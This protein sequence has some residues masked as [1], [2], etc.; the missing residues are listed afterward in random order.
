MTDPHAPIQVKSVSPV[1]VSIRVV[2][3]VT[4][5]PPNG[6][7]SPAIEHNG[8]VYVSGQLGRGPAMTDEAAGNIEVQTR[9][10]LAAVA[11]ILEAAG[12][13]MSLLL[14]VNIYISDVALWGDVN[15]VYRQVLGEHRP[16]RAIIPVA[17]LHF[18]ALL[19]IDAIAAVKSVATG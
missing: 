10:A 1:K 7:Y 11:E 6:H 8:V 15:A 14:K 17:A 12:S 4:S 13:D 5:P 16:A 18:N 2:Q 9:R 3:P 19:E